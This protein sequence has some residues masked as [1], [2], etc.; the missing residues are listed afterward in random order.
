MP[1]ERKKRK[2]RKGGGEAKSIIRIGSTLGDFTESAECD[3]IVVGVAM[4]IGS[5]LLV[6]LSCLLNP[7]SFFFHPLP[8]LYIPVNSLS[9]F[10]SLS[11]SNMIHRLL[12]MPRLSYPP[13]KR[14]HTFW[15]VETRA[16]YSSLPSMFLKKSS[17]NSASSCSKTTSC[18]S[19]GKLFALQPLTWHWSMLCVMSL[20]V[21]WLSSG[22]EGERK[23]WE[24]EGK[25]R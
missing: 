2:E 6:L 7:L 25:R 13:W 14:V 9:L 21:G 10:S 23:V 1:G 12:S 15:Q 5:V 20:I 3:P 16:S 18:S 24:R 4:C 11:C 22:G 19:R 8:S 17:F